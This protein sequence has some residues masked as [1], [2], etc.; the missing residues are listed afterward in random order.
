MRSAYWPI[1]WPEVGNSLASP[2]FFLGEMLVFLRLPGLLVFS[3]FCLALVEAKAFLKGGAACQLVIAVDRL[4]GANC[5]LCERCS[6][7]F[8]WPS[9]GA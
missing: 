9:A 3:G 7:V 6:L 4:F 8:A 5:D 2:L 1:H